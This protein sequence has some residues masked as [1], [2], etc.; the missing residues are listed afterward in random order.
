MRNEDQR[1][2]GSDVLSQE[3]WSLSGFASPRPVFQEWLSTTNRS[4]AIPQ[5]ST[6]ETGLELGCVLRRMPIL[7]ITILFSY[8]TFRVFQARPF[9]SLLHKTQGREVG[10]DL[11]KFE[12]S[13]HRS[14]SYLWIKLCT[15]YE[16]SGDQLARLERAKI[17]FSPDIVIII[18]EGFEFSKTQFKF[19][20][21]GK[22]N[23]GPITKHKKNCG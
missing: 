12:K 15:L 2:L 17:W 4:P 22:L 18:R 7:I 6:G 16:S 9:F 11:L 10:D 1:L 21:A 20:R 19:T 13:K 23:K 3:M 5:R 8:F 14:S